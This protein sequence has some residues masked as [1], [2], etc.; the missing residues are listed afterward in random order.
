M[1]REVP[2]CVQGLIL[3]S[4]PCLFL[5]TYETDMIINDLEYISM[6]EA[7]KLFLLSNDRFGRL[8]QKYFIPNGVRIYNTS[9]NHKGIK[10]CKVD[11]ETVWAVAVNHNMR[12]IDIILTK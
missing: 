8:L 1:F 6:T 12:L 2:L 4:S 10:I 3:F 5:L 11:L 7:A 9:R